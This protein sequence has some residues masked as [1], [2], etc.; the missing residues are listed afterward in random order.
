MNENKKP[1]EKLIIGAAA[2]RLAKNNDVRMDADFLKKLDDEVKDK[3]K[4]AIERAKGN[5]R[6]T[7]K[8]CDL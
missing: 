8:P 1:E 7:L 5:K 4:V 2:K 3:M 6:K